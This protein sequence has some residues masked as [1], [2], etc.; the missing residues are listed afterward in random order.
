MRFT[1]DLRKM[2]FKTNGKN[3]SRQRHKS[4]TTKYTE[5]KISSLVKGKTKLFVWFVR[6]ETTAVLDVP[7]ELLCIVQCSVSFQ[8]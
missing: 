1:A 3:E 5:Q 8:F 7:L 6:S 2:G 4:Q